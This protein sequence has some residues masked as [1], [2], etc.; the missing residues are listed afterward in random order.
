M[1]CPSSQSSKS[2]RPAG[3]SWESAPG[4]NSPHHHCQWS[5]RKILFS[6]SFVKFQSSVLLTR[7]RLDP[8]KNRTNMDEKDSKGTSTR[9]FSDGRVHYRS[10]W[11]DGG[12]QRGGGGKKIGSSPFENLLLFMIIKSNY[13]F[14]ILTNKMSFY[15]ILRLMSSPFRFCCPS[16]KIDSPTR[17]RTMFLVYYSLRWFRHR[18]G[19]TLY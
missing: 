5:G 10:T 19:F 7:G 16:R 1:G 3:S 15:D 14:F 9:R 6:C 12:S 11:R 18:I 17:H 8:W 4:V 2:T 13:E